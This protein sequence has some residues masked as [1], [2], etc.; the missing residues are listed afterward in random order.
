M[1]FLQVLVVA[2]NEPFMTVDQMAWM[3]ERDSV[4]G[5]FNGKVE[6]HDG[7]LIINGK[8]ITVFS[9]KVSNSHIASATLNLIPIFRS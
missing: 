4:H 7:K 9:E 1:S 3:F 6:H 8:S 5:K 2:I